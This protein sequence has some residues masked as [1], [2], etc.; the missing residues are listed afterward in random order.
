MANADPIRSISDKSLP[1]FKCSVLSVSHCAEGLVGVG[2]LPGSLFRNDL[3][4]RTNPVPIILPLGQ[5]EQTW[6]SP[7]SSS[8]FEQTIDVV[9]RVLQR[10]VYY[11][12]S[13][14]RRKK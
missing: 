14:E 5:V 7:Q 11:Q 4:S 8:A 12:P 2:P 10:L 3:E 9:L 13:H 6:S 1:H